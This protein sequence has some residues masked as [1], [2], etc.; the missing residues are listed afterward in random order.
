MLGTGALERTLQIGARVRTNS[1]R[2]YFRCAVLTLLLVLVH[3]ALVDVRA[4]FLIFGQLKAVGAV[5]LEATLQ[6]H[7]MVAAVS[8]FLAFI[9]VWG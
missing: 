3:L 7:T 4:G 9:D 5:A 8:H 6:I 1:S 2:L